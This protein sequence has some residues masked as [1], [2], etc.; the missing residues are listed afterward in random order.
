[1][2]K[3]KKLYYVEGKNTNNF[4]RPGGGKFTILEHAMNRITDIKRRGG[5]AKLFETECNWQEIDIGE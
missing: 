5:T 2:A 1:M 4:W 3:P